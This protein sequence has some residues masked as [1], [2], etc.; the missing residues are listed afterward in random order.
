MLSQFLHLDHLFALFV[1]QLSHF[2][3]VLIQWDHSVVEA[4]LYDRDCVLECIILRQNIHNFFWEWVGWSDEIRNTLRIHTR[5]VNVSRLILQFLQ[6]FM[7]FLQVFEGCLLNRLSIRN[8]SHV[9]IDLVICVAQ[10]SFKVDQIVKWWFCT[11]SN[12]TADDIDLIQK[13][14]LFWVLNKRWDW[15]VLLSHCRLLWHLLLL[16]H[17]HELLGLTHIMIVLSKLRILSHLLLICWILSHLLGNSWMHWVSLWHLLL[18]RR[19]RL[20]DGLQET[21]EIFDVW[22]VV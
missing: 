8:V 14:L 21:H 9:S 17:S 7:L 13:F 18:N 12:I 1:G 11:H 10:V 5:L 4:F 6:I 16:V 2:L 3:Q 15:K 20:N 22:L 19:I